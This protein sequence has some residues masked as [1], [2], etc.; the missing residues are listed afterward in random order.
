MAVHG[1]SGNAVLM[2]THS[3]VMKESCAVSPC[4]LHNGAS[5]YKVSKS[6]KV[7]AFERLILWQIFAKA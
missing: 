5:Y 2:P 3:E 6:S 7:E 4:A 1:L